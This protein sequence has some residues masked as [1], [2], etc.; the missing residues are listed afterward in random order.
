MNDTDSKESIYIVFESGGIDYDPKIHGIFS[1]LKLAQDCIKKKILEFIR[2][3]MVI[4]QESMQEYGI[5]VDKQVYGNYVY[6]RVYQDETEQS[7]GAFSNVFVLYA[8]E[9]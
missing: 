5:V 1:E 4:G 6:F 7:Y 8:K 2:E 9:I 3:N